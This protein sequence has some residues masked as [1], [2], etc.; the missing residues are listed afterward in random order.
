MIEF[1]MNLSRFV[2]FQNIQRYFICFILDYIVCKSLQIVFNFMS[3]DNLISTNWKFVFMT[4]MKKRQNISC[5][6]YVAITKII[7]NI[8]RSS[9]KSSN[10]KSIQWVISILSR[11]VKWIEIWKDK[12]TQLYRQNVYNS[13]RFFKEIS[14]CFL[15]RNIAISWREIIAEMIFI[16]DIKLILTSRNAVW[17]FLTSSA[18]VI[19][20]A[21]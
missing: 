11:R 6:S 16:D 10:M 14:F 5:K 20:V 2:F 19:S 18:Y 13:L 8:D 4:T 21:L 1:S 3:L 9:W 17:L 15:K 7:N 12:N